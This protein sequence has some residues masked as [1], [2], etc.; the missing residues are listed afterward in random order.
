[1]LSSINPRRS[2]SV[3]YKRNAIAW[4][5][6][7][8]RIPLSNAAAWLNVYPK[9]LSEWMLQDQVLQSAPLNARS[10]HCGPI[11]EFMDVE[12][13]LLEWVVEIRTRPQPLP[14]DRRVL[15]HQAKVFAEGRMDDRSE[16]QLYSWI[17]NFLRRNCHRLTTRRVTSTS[18]ILTRLSHEDIKQF[19]ENLKQLR[20]CH[21]IGS[22]RVMNM[23]ETGIWMEMTSSET[24]TLVG[25]QV[26]R[27]ATGGA[28]KA[29]VTAVFV[30]RA[31]GFK[32]KPLL[33]FKA[34]KDGIL[35][36]R[37]ESNPLCL[38]ETFF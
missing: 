27:V 10:L 33:I 35:N 13:K 24:I 29:R 4:Y 18:Q 20:L 6:K 2:F 21:H 23:D 17:S 38:L 37:Y 3:E 30:V 14:I 5:K 34:E 28:E 1:M 32:F 16:Q 25:E 12:T 22:N 19:H 31:D 9:T 8:H 26:T 15:I 36:A 7:N 11:P